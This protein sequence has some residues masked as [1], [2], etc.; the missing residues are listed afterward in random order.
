[1]KVPTTFEELHQTLLFYSGITSILFGPRSALVAGAKSFARAISSEKIIFKGRIAS[2]RKLPAKILYAMEIRIQRWLGECIKF[3]D[4]SMVNDCLVSFDEVF[5]MVM[6]STINMSLPPNFVKP[7]PKSP[8]TSTGASS[9]EG[10]GKKK[11]G[12]KRKSGE[13]DRERITKNPSP[14]PEFLLKDGENWKKQFAGK[15][16]NDRPKWDNSTFMC[17]RWHIRGECFVD[18][19]NKASHVGASAI[20]QAKKDDFLAYIT[21]VCWENKPSTSA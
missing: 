15:C 5:E 10:D 20:P 12:N 2:D 17:A 14:I 7:A 16:S 21:K 6:N 18:C 3:D 4:H 9:A 19:N 13:V 8:P 11:G 1:M